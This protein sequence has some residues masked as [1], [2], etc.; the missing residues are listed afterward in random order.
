MT[1]L[2]PQRASVPG[3]NENMIL[4]AVENI[5]ASIQPGNAPRLTT[6][7]VSR[8]YTTAVQK[9][10]RDRTVPA[11]TIPSEHPFASVRRTSVSY[12]HSPSGRLMAIMEVELT[13]RVMAEDQYQADAALHSFED[14]VI[15]AMYSGYA[16]DP[17]NVSGDV[18][19]YAHNVKL[20]DTKENLVEGTNNQAES[21]M[22]WE[23]KFMRSTGKEVAH[24]GYNP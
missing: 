6:A 21:H 2:P 9:V 19:G 23:I 8:N 16:M 7:G 20:V 14:D 13:L 3:L 24:T 1:V 12:E 10:T 15:A 17:D 18:S 4:L 22:T 11:D 5:L